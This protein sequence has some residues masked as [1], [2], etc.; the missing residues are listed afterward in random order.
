MRARVFVL[1]VVMSVLLALS[2]AGCE[3]GPAVPGVTDKEIK[4]GVQTIL[5]GPYASDGAET[6]RSVD[7]FVEQINK[8][9]GVNGRLIK[10]VYADDAYDATKAVLAVR[11]LIDQE[12]VFAIV[13]PGGTSTAL[14]VRPIIEEAGIPTITTTAASYTIVDPVPKYM[15]MANQ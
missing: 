7:L 5:T 11:Q 10:V 14:A 12:Q 8:A 1:S 15:F 2:L 13:G 9:G 3:K 6:V 4:I